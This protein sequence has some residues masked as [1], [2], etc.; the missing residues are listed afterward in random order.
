MSFIW[1]LRLPSG[2]YER[3]ADDF[4]ARYPT[5]ERS[6]VWL[7]LTFASVARR[8]FHS[9]G[10]CTAGIQLIK[11]GRYY[12]RHRRIDRVPYPINGLLQGGHSNGK[13]D[14]NIEQI[15]ERNTIFF[16]CF[17]FFLWHVI[18]ILPRC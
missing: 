13:S 1:V 18:P 15:P 9:L 11:V 4:L 12:G 6:I 3:G 7:R 2:R 17:A 5:Q 8:E 10:R 14:I 16:F